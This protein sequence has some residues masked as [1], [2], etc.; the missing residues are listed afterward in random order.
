MFLR[1][2][3]LTPSFVY[4]KLKGSIFGLSTFELLTV[5]GAGKDKILLTEENYLLN[6]MPSHVCP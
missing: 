6:Q 4:K 2:S 3:V 1:F 5:E